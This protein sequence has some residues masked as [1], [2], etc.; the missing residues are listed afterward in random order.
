MKEPTQCPS[1]PF[2]EIVTRILSLNLMRVTSV[3]IPW[4]TPATCLVT[5]G[6]GRF[7]GS[8]SRL[9]SNGS[10]M[11][12]SFFSFTGDA[13]DRYSDQMLNSSSSS[14]ESDEGDDESLGVEM[15][16]VA[17]RAVKPVSPLSGQNVAA[18]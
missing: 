13:L 7:R 10:L 1:R 18:A 6:K 16:S 14:L 17:P 8:W 5:A 12:L 4:M 15:W 9:M 3:W 2:C 11:V